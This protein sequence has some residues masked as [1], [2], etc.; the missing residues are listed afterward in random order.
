MSGFSHWTQASGS[1]ISDN[2]VYS[3]Y[4]E[5]S[6][7]LAGTR[8]NGV[9]YS[10]NYGKNWTK[11]SD[12]D[13]GV[14]GVFMNGLNALA[15]PS[16]DGLY[17]SSN[18]GKNWT[19]TDLS[20]KDFSTVFIDGLNTIAGTLNNGV[21]YSSNYGKNWTPTN[22]SDVTVRS[23]FMEGSNAIA[24]TDR[25]V[26]YSS[27]SGKNWSQSS[28]IDRSVYTVFME[29]S[30]ALASPSGDGLY[31]SSNSGKNW[32]KNSDID[33]G[34]YGVFMEGS[35]AIAGTLNNGVYYSSNYG[36]NWSQS[37]DIDGSFYEVFIDGL[38]ALA[39]P[40]GYGLYYSTLNFVCFKQDAKILTDKGY[41]KI[42]DL[43]PGD[44]VKT[45]SNGFK[46]IHSIGKRDIHHPASS[47]R[48]KDQLYLCSK[49][50]YPELFE[51]LV[52]TGG[53]SILV[54]KFKDDIQ[55]EKNISFFKGI[56]ETEGYY[57]LLACVDDRASVYSE[58]GYYTIYHFALEN[59]DCCV[60]YGVYANGLL[61]EKCNKKYLNEFHGMEL[62]E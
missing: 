43:H 39:V 44:L 42:Q 27:N 3:V 26:Y 5:G 36:K 48:I 24:G 31:Y 47:E 57:N 18:S 52:I 15:V 7:A 19:P 6:N 54:S 20:D 4:M 21:Y 30:N 51:D 11:N 53:H 2:F 13:G 14:Y 58:A 41:I 10:S 22:L 62:I 55:R 29:G 60:N 35:N 37:S 45:L 23:V 38:N 49:E 16:G 1:N 56:V 17:Y 25:G 28:D 46:H 61:V 50:H 8:H 34:V 32:T 40:E 59:N 12:I 33:G 9:Y